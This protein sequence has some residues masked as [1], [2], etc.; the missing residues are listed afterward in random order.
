VTPPERALASAAPAAPASPAAP[1]WDEGRAAAAPRVTVAV[2]T[3]NR[4]HLVGRAI[5]S[6]LAQT[7]ED[8]EV[9]VVDDGSTDGTPEALARFDD[10][11]LRTVRLERNSGISR[12]RNTALALARGEW[13]AFLD[14]DNEWLPD[15]LS[16]QL[17][18]AASRP[19]SDVVYCRAQRRDG[20]T[21]HDGVMPEVIREGPVFRHVLRGWLPLMSCALVRRSALR[22]VGGLDEALKASED[23]DLWLRLAQRTDFAG[24][25]DVLVVRHMHPGAHLSRN[26]AFIAQDAAVLEVKWKATVLASCG[27]VAYRQWRALLVTSAQIVRAMQAADEGKLLEGLRCLGR[28]APHLPWSAPSVV[29]GLVLAVL[30]PKAYVRLALARSML[31]TRAAVL[32]GL[33]HGGRRGARERPPAQRESA[34]R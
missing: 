23:R 4:A 3:W 5:D 12:A 32:G 15:Y 25:S 6:A 27:W 2:S 13:L 28:M 24:S 22:E 19:N 26:Y 9:L 31:R 8:I 7:F 20:R 29:R 17:A 34:R 18:L 10:R 16:R 33:A 21:G 1:A 14:D 30:G 11:R